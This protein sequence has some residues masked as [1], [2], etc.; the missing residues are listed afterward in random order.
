MTYSIRVVPSVWMAWKKNK[1]LQEYKTLRTNTSINPVPLESMKD[2]KEIILHS[3]NPAYWVGLGV[4]RILDKKF[5]LI[6]TTKRGDIP[7]FDFPKGT[8]G[9]SILKF[10]R[11]EVEFKRRADIT[12]VPMLMGHVYIDKNGEKRVI[13]LKHLKQWW[14]EDH[15][16]VEF[17]GPDF[18]KQGLGGKYLVKGKVD[19]RGLSKGAKKQFARIMFLSMLDGNAP[20]ERPRLNKYL[21]ET[22]RAALKDLNNQLGKKGKKLKPGDFLDVLVSKK[23]NDLS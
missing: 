1:S 4:I 13:S 9:R 8:R 11:K 3:S 18:D 16:P 5:H 21:D 19:M 23:P 6:R 15:P 12:E 7:T 17:R 2:M 22:Q 14:G 10:I 20:I